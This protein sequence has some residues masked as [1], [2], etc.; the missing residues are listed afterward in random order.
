MQQETVKINTIKEVFNPRSDFSKVDEISDSI[1]QVGQLYP[2]LVTKATDGTHTVVDGA[3]RLR[4]LKKLNRT[5]A[6][7]KIIDASSAD[8]AQLHVAL[9]R[10]DLNVLERA[11][12]FAR[13]IQLYPTKHN[14][15]SLAKMFGIK[16]VKTVERMISIVKRIPANFDG[17]LSPLMGR[18]DL[19]DLEVLAQVP[20]DKTRAMD[21]V[22]EA[23][24]I[25]NPDISDALNKACKELDFGGDALNSGKLV[26]EGK[27]FEIKFKGNYESVYTADP[28][29]FKKAKADYEEILRKRNK[30]SEYGGE[31]KKAK[32]KSEA[33]MEKERA[34]RKKEREAKAAAVAA[35]PKLLEKFMAKKAD[36]D[37]IAKLGL[38]LVNRHLDA[39]HS[40]LILVAFGMDAKKADQVGYMTVQN[41]VWKRLAPFCKTSES[42]VRLNQFLH[43]K[44]FG[45][46]SAQELWADGLKK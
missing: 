14:A 43:I 30:S 21:K 12:G 37:E 2:I 19:D 7:V 10:S 42:L 45:A 26:S 6:L 32:V 46:K 1:K 16:S 13:L 33:Q 41:E 25:Q 8:E 34:A 24:S 31:Q 38:E 35:L 20:N 39:T 4:A 11:R 23:I 5:D 3:Q 44:H 22:I 9:M 36:A 17:K 15:A 18:I 40:R 28:E 27:A 29:V